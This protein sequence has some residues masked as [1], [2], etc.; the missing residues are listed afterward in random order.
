MSRRS[1][2]EREDAIYSGQARIAMAFISLTAAA[3][4]VW[5][6]LV[7]LELYAHSVHPNR[8]VPV[9]L[10]A[11][12]YTFASVPV[13]AALLALALLKGPLVRPLRV[14]CGIIGF[15]LFILTAMTYS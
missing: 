14:I 3:A 5:L 6:V 4:G 8:G 13:G 11:A 1:R 12:V 9:G 10:A 2:I 15:V 7:N